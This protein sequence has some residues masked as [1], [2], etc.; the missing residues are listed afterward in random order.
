MPQPGPWVFP[1]DTANKRELFR[2]FFAELWAMMFFVF[3][4]WCVVA[5]LPTVSLKEELTHPLTAARSWPRA[6]SSW[7]RKA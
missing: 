7:T 2:A 6:S 4:G 3:F 5:R 1:N